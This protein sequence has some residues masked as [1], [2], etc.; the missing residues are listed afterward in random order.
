MRPLWIGVMATALAAACA[1]SP[2]PVTAPTHTSPSAHPTTV[3]PAN[4]KRISR[5]LPPGYEVTRD[6][7]AG[8]SPRL[9]FGLGANATAQPAP[10]ATLADPG[11]G[12]DQSAQGVSG[13]GEGGIVGAVVVAVRPRPVA[14]GSDVVAGCAQW[15]MSDGHTSAAIRLI[16]P[17]HIDGAPTLAMVADVRTSVESGTE[18]DS[19]TYTF[20]AYL[21]DYYAFTTLTTDP[22][23]MLPPLPPRFAADLLVK[24]VS[25]LRG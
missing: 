2:A 9:V 17:P 23:S 6:I 22:G 25:T 4:I 14:P 10:C 19:R 15:A 12:R 20:I 3:N 21:G 11:H 13:S 18:I 16:D 8:A 1:Q 5:E 24:T 7:P